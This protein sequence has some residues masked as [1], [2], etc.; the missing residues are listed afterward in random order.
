MVQSADHTLLGVITKVTPS[1]LRYI[2]VIWFAID[3]EYTGDV[4][5][6]QR[7]WYRDEQ[8]DYV[9][10]IPEIK[11]WIKKERPLTL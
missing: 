5:F 2:Q 6:G 11:R 7:R 3:E 1:P 9:D 8:L 4:E 10:L